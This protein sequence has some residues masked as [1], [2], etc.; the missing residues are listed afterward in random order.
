MSNTYQLSR[1]E[2]KIYTLTV[3]NT[4]GV[5]V[6]LGGASIYFLVRGLD[7]LVVLTKKSTAAGGSDDEIEIPA[8]AGDDLGTFYLKLGTTD[9]DIDQTARW[10]DCWVVTD[11]VPPENLKVDSHA[12]F[13]ITGD[14]PPAFV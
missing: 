11:A 1:G 13:Y 7:G 6:N 8:Q 14:E 5:L 10:A 9:T 2:T 4:A 3:R 12:P